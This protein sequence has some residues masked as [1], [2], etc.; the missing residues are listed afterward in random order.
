MVLSPLQLRK[1]Y[2]E[3]FYCK[4]NDRFSKERQIETADLKVSFESAVSEHDPL[5]RKIRLFIEQDVE[6]DGNTPY[7]FKVVMV[8]FFE[9]DKDFFRTQGAEKTEQLANVNG[10]A[11]LYSA[12][13]ELLVLFSGRGPYQEMDLTILL[14]S[15][16]FI[17]FERMEEI[18]KLEHSQKGKKQRKNT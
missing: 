7:S 13:R 9:I 16:T 3:E 2:V 14:P 15:I 6:K 12:A 10:P 17:N 4:A 8:A 1:Y 11:L 18:P 5:K